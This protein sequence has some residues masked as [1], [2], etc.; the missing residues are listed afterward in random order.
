MHLSM[1]DNGIIIFF[2][3][4]RWSIKTA[5]MIFGIIPLT[6]CGS[7]YKE[8]GGKVTFDGKEITDKSFIVLND[9]FAKNDKTAYYKAY[10]IP[11]ADVKT[12]VALDKHFAKDNNNAYYCDEEREG[13]NY[14]LTKHS[15]IIKIR[16]VHSPSFAILGDGYSGFAKDKKRGYFKGV[17]FDVKDAA[18][19]SI[20]DGHFVKDKYQVYFEQKPVKGADVNSFSILNSSYAKDTNWVYYYGYHSQE[21]NGIHEIPCDVASFSL[22]EYPYSKDNKFAFYVYSKIAG[23]DAGSFSVVGNGFSKDKNHVYFEL[24]KLKGADAASFRMLPHVESLDD[25]I[26]TKDNTHIFFNDKMFIEADI[27][28]FKVL[29]LGYAADK[30]HVYFCE[31][32]VKNADPATF[33]VFDHAYGDADSEDSDQKFLEGKKVIENQ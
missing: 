8:K 27:E 9:A 12:F 20:I 21:L 18:S 17:A 31:R 15:V 11:D 6:R 30:K 16:E 1:K 28:S 5:L 14:Y 3:V 2:K 26:Y 32:I 13:Q 23:V 22:L 25:F 7:G 29:G 10:S 19:L 24:K 4:I 33:K